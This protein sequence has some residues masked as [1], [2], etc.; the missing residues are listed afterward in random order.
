MADEES[1]EQSAS[2]EPSDETPASSATERSRRTRL[3]PEQRRFLGPARS[4]H[5]QPPTS[6]T[7][8]RSE[9]TAAPAKIVQATS[10]EQEPELART[11]GRRWELSRAVE[12][13]NVALIFGALFLLGI[14]FF[15]GKKYDSLKYAFASRNDAKLS[16]VDSSKFAGI[17]AG[18]LVEQGLAAE[19]LG[20]WQDAADRFI[21]AKYK[22][23][24]YSG[25]L[26]RVGKLYYDHGDFDSADKV[27]ARAISF[28][29]NIDSA[30]YYRGMIAV[31]R[32]DFPAAERFFEAATNA[33]PFNADY[34][35]SLAE[36]LRK[37]RRP[38]E[39][40]TRYEQAAVRAGEQE[41]IVCQFKIRMTRVEADDLAPVNAELEKKQSA[42]PL[43]VDWIM[44]AAAMQIH[45]GN[46]DDAV[47]LVQE[48]RA[49]D[50]SHLFGLF[51]ACAGDRLFNSECQNHPELAKACQVGAAQEPTRP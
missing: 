2:G 10:R 12:M 38:Q 9:P 41:T 45:A 51:A 43:P 17:S 39:A 5:D 37:D 47:R 44:T 19:R 18:D 16:A 48:A 26:F 8:A 36:T 22:N 35:Y 33:A 21:A 13:Q 42:G 11:P 1:A 4:L 50:R 40:I 20:N 32:S 6:E 7:P 29:E 30:N 23:L 31:G 25:L 3:T 15:F 28:G 49:S 46:I 34:Y 24:S 27:F 14:T